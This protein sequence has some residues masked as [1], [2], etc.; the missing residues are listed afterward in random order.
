ME[1]KTAIPHLTA[2]HSWCQQCIY[3][4]GI[5][6]HGHS[7]YPSLFTS[8]WWN[9]P[10]PKYKF[11]TR[12]PFKF[13]SAKNSPWVDCGYGSYTEGKPYLNQPI[14]SSFPLE[15][16]Q[17]GKAKLIPRRIL[18]RVFPLCLILNFHPTYLSISF[19]NFSSMTWH[20]WTQPFC[21]KDHSLGPSLHNPI[22][23]SSSNTTPFS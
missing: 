8:S 1:W 5:H 9:K 2:D 15:L 6:I 22:L 16:S 17:K 13:I 18:S 19:F 10:H 4:L 11:S 23:A 21:T 7:L 3:F 20:L 12:T 14:D